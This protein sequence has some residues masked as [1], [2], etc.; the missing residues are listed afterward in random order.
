MVDF[1]ELR[2]QAEKLLGEH[3]D[4]VDDGI[5][6]LA[7]EAGKRFGHASQ[8]DQAAE[9]LKGFVDEQQ[10]GQHPKQGGGRQRPKQG[11][12]QRGPRQGTGAARNQGRRPRTD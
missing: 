6:K 4:Q 2:H 5:E 8:I 1:D 10:A 12:G 3:G 7:D 11:G 9:K